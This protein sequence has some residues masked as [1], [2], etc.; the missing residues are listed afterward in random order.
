VTRCAIEAAAEPLAGTAP[1]ARWWWL[2]EV[3]GSWSRQAVK[4]CRIPAVRALT[5]H[6]QRR[7]ILVRRPGRHPATDDRAPLRVWFAG[8]MPGDPPVRLAVAN[9]PGEIL[10][11]PIEG[12]T[13]AVPD[14][15]APVLAV[16]TNSSRDL[17]CGIDGRALVN[18]LADDPGVW[19]CSHLGGHRFAPT[20][21]HVPTGLVYGRLISDAARRLL[22]QGPNA[23]TAAWLRGRSALA[24]HVQ[25]AEVELLERGVVPDLNALRVESTDDSALVAFVG[26]PALRLRRASGNERPESCGGTPVASASWQVVERLAPRGLE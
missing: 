14:P 20:A 5:S 26:A 15:H 10:D 21:L 13:T 19:E 2:I 11:W 23:D 9:D 24:P 22:A 16:C 12:P 17:C 6:D 25:A 4:D 1:R 3:P 7:V 8:A 18:A